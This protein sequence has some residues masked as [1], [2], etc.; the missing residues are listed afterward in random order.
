[1]LNSR[2]LAYEAQQAYY[3]GLQPH[4]ALASITSTPAIAAGL[5]HRIGILQ[6]GADADVVLWD[7]HPLQ[8]GATPK[9]VWIDGILQIPV[10]S[11]ETGKRRPIEIG[12]GKDGEEWQRAPGVPNWDKEREEALKWEG[13]PPL[14][15]RN[16]DKRVLF[17]N[18]K[19]V[20]TRS[21]GAMIQLDPLGSGDNSL[22]ASASGVRVLVED[23]RITCVG[24]LC[25]TEFQE[26]NNIDLKGGSI[27]PGL[28]SYGS[29]LG[30]E[31]MAGEPST[32]DGGLYDALKHNVP[33]LMD[34]VGGVVRAGDA[35]MF[36]TRNAL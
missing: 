25:A 21:N 30:L 4:L 22:N 19:Q 12:K 35:L 20:W 8:L 34:D 13:L 5:S 18:V 27:S 3:F 14:K 23:G 33:K 26:A 29:P 24:P 7:S 1:M 17:T 11:S 15:G 31:E 16:S 2:Y 36:Q 28:M 10:V 6:K 32:G 9:R